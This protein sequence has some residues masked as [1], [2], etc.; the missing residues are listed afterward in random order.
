MSQQIDAALIKQYDNNFTMLYQQSKSGLRPF[1]RNETQNAD[2][3]F[4]DFIGEVEGEEVSDRHGDSPQM[5]TPH[6]RRKCTLKMW[7]VGDFVDDFDK[8]RMLKDPSSEYVRAFAAAANRWDDTTIL[9]ALG[10]TAYAGKEGN[11][12]VNNY[13][14]GECRLIDGDGTVVTAGS[15]H[16]GS[17]ETGLTLAKIAQCGQL[18]DDASVPETDRHIV[19]NTNQKWYLLGS[20]KATSADYNG[21]RALVHGEINTYLGFMFHWL[22]SARFTENATDTGCYECYA[23]HKSA[24]VYASGVGPGVSQETQITKRA[25]KRYSTYIY[26]KRFGGAVRVQGPGVIEILLDKDPSIDF[27]QS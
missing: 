8:V 19:A 5:D 11:T 12:S 14:A 20:T 3:K 22:P 6:S 25:D 24:I 4:Y 10:G 1:V 21:V 26:A 17:T 27:S 18:L 15:D 16:S 2:A 7:D 9:A 13:D 23:F